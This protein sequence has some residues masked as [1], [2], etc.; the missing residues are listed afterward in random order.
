M[1]SNLG[2]RV[3]FLYIK[4]HIIMIIITDI[5]YSL[6]CI[7]FFFHWI[8]C[9]F[10]PLYVFYLNTYHW[11]EQMPINSCWINKSSYIY[12]VI[13]AFN[14]VIFFAPRVLSG[15]CRAE[16]CRKHFRHADECTDEQT[17]EGRDADAAFHSPRKS[18]FAAW[19]W[20]HVRLN[21]VFI[22]TSWQTNKKKN[23]VFALLEYEQPKEKYEIHPHSKMR[24]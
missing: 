3:Y 7:N 4:C 17:A 15:Q 18:D 24:P 20:H 11:S 22:C 14:H 5:L 13:I 1:H 23:I 16:V 21:C 6:Q 10:L 8:Y 19:E 9:C 2:D 12:S